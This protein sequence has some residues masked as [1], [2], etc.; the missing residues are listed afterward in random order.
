MTQEQSFA[1]LSQVV[2]L[3]QG[4]NVAVNVSLSCVFGCPME[5]DVP[6]ADVFGWVQRFVDVGVCGCRRVW[7]WLCFLLTYI[8]F[9]RGSIK[10]FS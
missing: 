4:A 5:G 9:L 1:A 2:A 8:S 7:V 3:A 6:E 10:I